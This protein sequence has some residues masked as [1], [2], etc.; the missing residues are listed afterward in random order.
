M[1]ATDVSSQSVNWP[2]SFLPG[3]SPLFD[4]ARWLVLSSMSKCLPAAEDREPES[5]RGPEL[6]RWRVGHS[7]SKCGVSRAGFDPTQ[8]AT[9]AATVTAGKTYTASRGTNRGGA[10]VPTCPSLPSLREC[11]GR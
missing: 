11:K 1:P 7:G 6:A 8:L 5:D 2:T 9:S 4:P 3:I 10:L